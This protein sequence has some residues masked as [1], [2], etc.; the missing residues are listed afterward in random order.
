MEQRFREEH[1]HL[2]VM[3]GDYIGMMGRTSKPDIADVLRRRLAFYNAFRA[4]V[5]SEGAALER[6]RT[7]R[8]DRPVDRMLD[9]H[10]RR[11]RDV[12]PGYNALI[13]EWTPPR[14]VAEWPVYC[15]AVR[16]QVKRYLEFLLWEE[17]EV[18][19]LL[20]H[21]HGHVAPASIMRPSLRA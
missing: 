8:A 18:L 13:R 14:I 2:R 3:L 16:A 19:P 5:A 15:R 1:D 7:G 4:H 12:M 17:A 11:L 21:A 6:L 10:D 20:G 9:A